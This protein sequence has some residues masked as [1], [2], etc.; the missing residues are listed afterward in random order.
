MNFKKRGML[1]TPITFHYFGWKSKISQK[2][3]TLSISIKKEIA[4]GCGLSKGAT[5]YCYLACDHKQRPL[6]IAYLDGKERF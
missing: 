1:M 2:R 4:Q 3:S 5:L 6:L